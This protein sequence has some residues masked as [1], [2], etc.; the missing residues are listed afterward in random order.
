MYDST[1]EYYININEEN[2]NFN[3]N[4]VHKTHLKSRIK[5]IKTPHD[6]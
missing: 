5:I 3:Y 4:K 2:F 6:K 1:M